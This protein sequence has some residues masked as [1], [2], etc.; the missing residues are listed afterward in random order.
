MLA[1]LYRT[2]GSSSVLSVEDV[3]VPEPGPGEVRVRLRV[4]GVN[5]TDWKS[6]STA[7]L[8]GPFQVPGQD[9]AGDVDAVGRGVDP[10]RV[11]ERVWVWFAAANGRPWGTLA[12]WTVVP[13]HQAV[14]LPDDASYDLGAG[15]GIPAMTAWHCLFWDGD[16]RGQ[17]VVVA[18]GAGA[19]GNAAVSLA[20]HAGARVVST[21]STAQKAALARAAGAHAVVDYRAPD[22]AER[23]RAEAPAGVHRVVEVALG[24]NLELDLAVVRPHA[25]IAVYADDELRTRIRPLMVANLT[26]RFMLVYGLPREALD[27]AVRG[28]GEAL[29]GGVL[30]PLP[31]T[32]FALRDA[33]AAHD[34]VESGTPG[35]VLVDLPD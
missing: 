12:Q 5:P 1:A 31:A 34:A 13:A 3:P 24:A 19:V 7:A 18:G 11:G 26:V 35:K 17:T 4:A 16:L 9:G 10:G 25:T 22:A 14:R 15:L 6:R 27:A 21:A 28:V 20:A 30:R 2:P 32:R 29:R 8:A 33:A 23:I